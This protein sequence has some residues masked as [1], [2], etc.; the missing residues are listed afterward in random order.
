ME[1]ALLAAR[2]LLFGVL[3]VAG[4]N[5]LA[6]RAGSRQALIDF[7]MPRAFA[8]PLY[9]LLLMIELAAGMA[10]VPARTAWFGAITALGL[11]LLFSGVIAVN[12]A[13][14]RK[15][16]CHCFGQLSS[17]PIG[18]PTLARNGALATIAAFVA[19]QG[20]GQSGPS[21]VVWI[22]RLTPEGQAALAFAVVALVG[23]GLE[24]WTLL[25][26]LRQQGRL[27]LRLEAIEARLVSSSG[28]Q[29]SA[30]AEVPVQGLPIGT[31]APNF[32]LDSLSGEPLTLDHLLASH[33]PVL[34]LF[35]NPNC[36]PCEA[37]M[38]EV[39]RWQREHSATLTIALVSEGSAKDN[40]AWG[41]QHGIAPIL[42]QHKREAAEAYKA[43]GTPGAVLIGT[44]RSIGSALAMG[45]EAIRALVSQVVSSG[46][47]QA[48][49]ALVRASGGNDGGAQRLP[50]IEVGQ[51][52]PAL[53][54]SDLN[55]RPSS[56]SE[57][58]GKETLLLFWNP[59]CGFCQAMVKD[60]KFWEDHAPSSAPNLLL[61]SSGTVE[62]VE[63]NLAMG[64]RSRIVLD[65]SFQAGRAF[66]ATGT[67]MA[68]LLDAEGRVASRVAAGAEAIMRLAGTKLT[69]SAIV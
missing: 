48:A 14:G 9:V 17:S 68:V 38:P 23:L 21:L 12:L 32:R 51:Q 11:L 3:V 54:F 62:D 2:L 57:F 35:T 6:D 31:P 41:T 58:R 10:L 29:G 65:S 50:R 61:L 4:L 25:Q 22:T 5:K 34:L 18:W 67:P 55:G 16:N 64:L 60:L 69:S 20:A 43:Y 52:A 56:L 8:S 19:W 42:L 59:H 66:G 45:A 28:P 53:V 1:A 49:S 63:D 39:R 36:G 47:H 26:I 7:G 30:N 40:R 46:S 37:L 33:K 13:L 27:L 24:A 15:P 44:D